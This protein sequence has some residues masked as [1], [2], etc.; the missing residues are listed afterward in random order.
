MAAEKVW[1]I[2]DDKLVHRLSV[3][4]GDKVFCPECG[5]SLT[6]VSRGDNDE[7]SHFRCSTGGCSGGAPETILHRMAKE[8]FIG[9]SGY[10]LPAWNA[11]LP[12]KQDGVY[13][14]AE[15]EVLKG[16][17]FHVDKVMI[18]PHGMD[19]P[20]LQDDRTVLERLSVVPDVALIASELD[21]GTKYIFIEITNTHRVDKA[22][23][24][25][26]SN[27][28]GAYVVSVD[29]RKYRGM[30]NR[31]DTSWVEDYRR[32]VLHGGK[33]VYSDNVWVLSQALK[34]GTYRAS[35]DKLTLCPIWEDNPTA[36]KVSDCDKCPF[37]LSRNGTSVECLGKGAFA[38]KAFL[39]SEL[40]HDLS[41]DERLDGVCLPE[42]Y[43]KVVVSEEAP[44][45]G[46]C[47]KCGRPTVFAQN[48]G[49]V[50][51]ANHYKLKGDTA[52]KYC[53]SCG[54][55]WEIRCPKCKKHNM[56][57]KR[58]HMDKVFL[59]CPDRED[60]GGCGLS[61]T[62]FSSCPCTAENY[63]DELR[64]VG[65]IDSF[66]NNF[67]EAYKKVMELRDRYRAK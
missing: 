54:K 28:V 32:D 36:V 47:P 1:G 58:S 44:M 55:L 16:R 22:K 37:C 61:L 20:V 15:V 30:I 52:G 13:R 10:E 2:R 50:G 38:N 8:F 7:S 63:G 67:R 31:D 6:I 49:T 23:L 27:V 53:V 21:G 14:G 24:E 11:V 51:V 12:Q 39:L 66:L 41:R 40:T 19:V 34:R 33:L 18:E 48:N 46:V 45:E 64:A 4:K 3:V 43:G 42:A 25:V 56:I 60:E 65:G 9:V 29:V 17:S 59:K 5:Q 35:G 62:L 26:Y 57:L